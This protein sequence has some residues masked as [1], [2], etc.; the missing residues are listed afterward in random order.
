MA[1]KDFRLTALLAVRDQ[2]SP[3]IQSVSKRWDG[4]RQTVESTEFRNLQRQM[5]YTIRSI[6]NVGSK[7]SSI[8]RQITGA[9]AAVAGAFGLGLRSAA[10]GY[11]QIGDAIDK[12]AARTGISAQTLQ[13]WGYAAQSAGANSQQ[14]EDGLKDFAKH[15]AE[16]ASGKDTTS[17][18][19][20]LFKALGISVKDAGGNIRPVSAVFNE[21]ADAIQRNENPAMRARMAMAAMGE[22]GRK[23][24]PMLAN[25]S[26]GL[27]AMAD[28]ARELGLV[29]SD[30]DVRGAAELST[31]LA[32]T[33]LVMQALSNTI[34]ARVA[35]IVRRLSDTLMSVVSAN[36]E[37]F[38]ERFAQVAERFAET[39]S[40]IDF[41]GIVIGLMEIADVALRA[42]NALGGFNTVMYAMGAIM[43]GKA[44]VSIVSF[45]SA[46]VTMISAIT[47]VAKAIRAMNLALLANPIVLAVAAIA[48][49]VGAVVYFWDDIVSAV[50]AAV[51]AISAF[52]SDLWQGVKDG[53]NA[54]VSWFTSA[55]DRVVSL[56]S[57]V[58][59]TISN[60]F[61]L[62]WEG[63]KDSAVDAFNSLIDTI[64]EIFT[65]I[66][67]TRLIPAPIRTLISSF[68]PDQSDGAEQTNNTVSNI[69]SAVV[70]ANAPDVRMQGQIGIRVM[71]AGGTSAQIESVSASEG[72]SIVGSIGRSDRSE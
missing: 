47:G 19:A 64:R 66:D 16:I 13:E 68:M 51:A 43:A 38:S 34:G 63:I 15:M 14:L 56:V 30:E 52:L 46:L 1:G 40:K 48:A 8:A 18:A 7:A 45:G 49:A 65:K 3:V 53:A 12:M 61:S 11:A 54:I 22:G 50:S 36:K 42:F 33:R 29:M 9:F 58:A 10:T 37:A 5:R 71:A 60:I 62:I 6:E 41:Q 27:K 20:T 57:D 59:E 2:L 44:L 35:P 25:G 39:L 4:F 23:L 28:R 70:L 31:A 32:D 69:Q 21:F 26:A 24:V 55:F 67:F 72:L 17:D